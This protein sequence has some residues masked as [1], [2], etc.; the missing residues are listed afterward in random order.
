MNTEGKILVVDQ[1]GMSW[2]LPKGHVD[3]DENLLEAAKREIYE[4]TGITDLTLVE[5]LG[6]FKRPGGN[7]P[8]EFKTITIFLFT[9][10]Q[11]DLKPIDPHNPEARWVEQDKVSDI[12]THPEDKKFFESV[13]HHL[14][15]SVRFK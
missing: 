7:D 13:R 12:L 10:K 9:T 14:P 15:R 2:S 4:E 6:S 11:T 5:K 1:R 8:D 3:A